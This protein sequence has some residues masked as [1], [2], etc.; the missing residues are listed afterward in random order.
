MAGG[1]HCSSDLSDPF[2]DLRVQG[3]GTAL[4]VA[5]QYGHSKVVDTLLKN[6]ANV[7]D[8]LLVRDF[9]PPLSYSCKGPDVIC[10]DGNRTERVYIIIIY[11]FQLYKCYIGC[12]RTP[13]QLK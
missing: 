5:S 6:G 2:N 1:G 12:V 10:K 9:F 11:L 8:Q 13:N 7:N 4:T 3:G